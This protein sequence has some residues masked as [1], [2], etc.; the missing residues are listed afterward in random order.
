MERKRVTIENLLHQRQEFGAD[1]YDEGLEIIESRVFGELNRFS[2]VRIP[3]NV[4]ERAPDAFE[5][6]VT[7][8]FD[9][10]SDCALT[11]HIE[12]SYSFFREICERYRY[13]YIT[14]DERLQPLREGVSEGVLWLSKQ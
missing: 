14:A 6:G 11:F 12:K 5:P 7:V 2:A 13:G 3:A 8:I 4:K 10:R 9:E 1:E